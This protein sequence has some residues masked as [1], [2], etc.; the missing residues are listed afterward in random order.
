MS[1]EL[2]Q[3]YAIVCRMGG[4]KTDPLK[5][6]KVKAV[7]KALAELDKKL[8]DK[9]KIQQKIENRVNEVLKVL[10]S[11]AN[12]DYSKK[13]PLTNKGDYIDA[14]ASGIN[15]L[16][17]ELQASTV[18]LREKEVLLKEIHHRVKNNLQI[19]SSLLSLQSDYIQD[20]KSLERFMES[21]NRVR[22]MALV[23][24]QLYESK[25]LSEI[26][27][28]KYLV[29]LVDSLNSSY[30]FVKKDIISVDIEADMH[31]FKID[32]A[33]PCGLIVNELLTNCYK[34][35]FPG[36]PDGGKIKI[37]FSKKNK[38]PE[39]NSCRLTV[40]DNGVGI[41]RDINIRNTRTL[42]L[43]LVNM[44]VDQL[45]GTIQL[46]RKK[47]TKFIITFNNIK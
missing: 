9:N 38:L 21:R 23:H 2:D 27:F 11:F 25:D 7:F 42:G 32:T 41:S 13:A 40:E 5:K 30:G 35:A 12:L 22:S 28:G 47:G 19:I 8:K 15:M 14:V 20:Q 45:D 3:I 37:V 16:G 10:M 29:M 44:L 34:Y 36:N 46:S 39:N 1:K 4:I 31:Y 33:I 6:D 26:D 18:S 24:E 43:Q 17:E